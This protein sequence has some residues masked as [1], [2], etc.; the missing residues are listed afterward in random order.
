MREG[1]IV[2]CIPKGYRNANHGKQMNPIL[3]KRMRNNVEFHEMDVTGRYNFCS[4]SR[5]VVRDKVVELAIVH[6]SS[7]HTNPQK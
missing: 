2:A 4:C 3:V 7:K 5:K 6:I 1:A